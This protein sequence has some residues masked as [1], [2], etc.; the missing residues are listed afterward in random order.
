MSME[1]VPEPSV[2]KDSSET[3]FKFIKRNDSDNS[4]PA[5]LS[6]TFDR[7]RGLLSPRNLLPRSRTPSGSRPDHRA[8]NCIGPEP[9]GLRHSSSRRN[10]LAFH[11]SKNRLNPSLRPGEG[12][13]DHGKFSDGFADQ[14]EQR[15]RSARTRLPSKLFRERLFFHQLHQ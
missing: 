7:N 13:L 1:R 11:R 14:H 5:A 2:K 12:N 8:R 6:D 9:T 4:P 10:R 3:G 15:T